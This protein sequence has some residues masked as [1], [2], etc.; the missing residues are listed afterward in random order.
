[1]LYCLVTT[2]KHFSKNDYISIIFVYQSPWQRCF[3]KF[4]LTVP[5][6]PLS[7][8]SRLGS[9]HLRL[10]FPIDQAPGGA[11]V[12]VLACRFPRILKL[13]LVCERQAVLCAECLRCFCLPTFAIS[14]SLRQR[15]K[16]GIADCKIVFWVRFLVS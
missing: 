14:R 16:S 1:M 10:A 12:D 5:D 4:F 11:A 7:I 2:T 13:V 3:Y 6:S 8:R 9:F 15:T